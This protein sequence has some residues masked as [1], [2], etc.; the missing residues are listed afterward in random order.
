MPARIRFAWDYF[1]GKN[2]TA[3]FAAGEQGRTM[4]NVEIDAK[5]QSWKGTIDTTAEAGKQGVPTQL[6]I[7]ALV[8]IFVIPGIA[9]AGLLLSRYADAERA[10]YQLESVNVA[11]AATAVIDRHL[12]GLQVVLR[13]LAT[14]AP[15][16]TGD[17]EGFHDQAA[18]LKI[19]ARADI[20]LRRPDGQQLIN[21][22]LPWGTPLPSTSFAID[23]E[24]MATGQPTV[25]DVFTEDAGHPMVAIV[26]P[27]TV[28][29]KPGYLLH[30][31]IETDVLREVIKNL[32]PPNW[33]VG[34]GDRKGVYV[35]RSRN[36]AEFSGK[37]GV[38]AFLS[39]AV[40]NEG[41]FTGESVFRENVL[42]GYT[43][44]A[45]SGWLIAASIKQETVESPL[46][47]GLYTLGTFGALALVATSAIGLWLWR[48]IARPLEALAI[49]SRHVGDARWVVPVRTSLREFVALRDA[50]HEAARQ[51][52]SHNDLLETRVAERTLELAR[53]NTELTA[54]MT[55]R[56]K[57][58]SQ[59]R[60]MQKMEA[61][62]QLTG[63]IAHD[64]NNMLSIVIGSLNLIQRRLDRGEADI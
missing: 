17:L 20:G 37:P 19:L 7:L 63:G 61:V 52:R 36:H 41:T 44:S 38:P 23:A 15:L 16:A 57:A 49:A 29:G 34:V 3:G 39:R 46:W 53:A 18:R 5:H 14:S 24:A 42:V 8:A 2:A 35:T 27:V 12:N 51:V 30:V 47:N 11:R 58:E 64:F 33:L 60:Q 21:T 32:V 43:R 54:Q 55:A 31:T 48:F 40:G 6:L 13:T 50:L 45:L 56:E 22:R 10:R 26:L 4:E 28:G 9:F 25:S 59:L 1:T 62:G